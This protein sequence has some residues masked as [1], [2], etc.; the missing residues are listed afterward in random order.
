MMANSI[1]LDYFDSAQL[2]ESLLVLCMLT[3]N[4]T[5]SNVW[6]LSN[7]ELLHVFVQLKLE[8]KKKKKKKKKKTCQ[9]QL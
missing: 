4:T 5:I 7:S 8:F 2:A 1:V 6:V 9:V 3:A